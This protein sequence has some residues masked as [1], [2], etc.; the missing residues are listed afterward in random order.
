MGAAIALLVREE[1]GRA[2][3][4][5]NAARIAWTSLI[6]I[7]VLVAMNRGFHWSDLP[8][9]VIGQSLAAI[10]FGALISLAVL[11]PRRLG[12]QVRKAFS[13]AW[14]RVLGKYSYAIYMF[15]APLH[16]VAKMWLADVVNRGGAA[17][18]LL[19][20]AAYDTGILMVSLLLALV[21]W[22]LLE[23]RFLMLKERLAPA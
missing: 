19:R 17:E 13:A 23:K 11:A 21:S 8:V 12:E 3:I 15:H 9:S 16:Q 4:A 18:R 14:L 5:A 7:M 2:W 6:G 10:F 22:N 20:L 1:R